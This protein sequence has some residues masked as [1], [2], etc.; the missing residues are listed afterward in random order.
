M[1]Q[2]VDSS[3]VGSAVMVAPHRPGPRVFISYRRD[4]SAGHAGRLRDDLEDALGPGS[5]FH[6]VDSLAPGERFADSIR[7]CI[8]AADIVYVVI[9][10]GWVDAR[11]HDGRRRLDDPDDVVRMEVETALRSERRT[12]PVLVGGASMPT[13][14]ALPDVLAPLLDAHATELRDSSW[15]AD[16]DRLLRSSGLIGEPLPRRRRLTQVAAAIAALSLLVPAIVWLASRGNGSESPRSPSAGSS[17]S[18]E[19]VDGIPKGTVPS[20]DPQPLPPDTEATL[21]LLG[22]VVNDWWAE[23]ATE[24][25]RRTIHVDVTITSLGTGGW[26]IE[27]SNFAFAV[28][29]LDQGPIS[30]AVL[31]DRPVMESGDKVRLLLTATVDDGVPLEVLGADSSAGTGVILDPG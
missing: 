23:P 27:A 11:A 2:P 9:G 14:D 24:S 18:A 3:D 20:E 26:S 12:A 25:D 5:V 21:G 31:Q 10:R 8:E 30:L 19:T 22:L 28:D 1:G 29:G 17:S 16:F 7:R 6:D 4:D 13:S 15:G